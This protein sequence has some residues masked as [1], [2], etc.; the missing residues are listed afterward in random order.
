MLVLVLVLAL[1]QVLV[2][3]LVLELVLVVVY[4]SISGLVVEV[5]RQQGIGRSGLPQRVEKRPHGPVA[6][7]ARASRPETRASGLTREQSANLL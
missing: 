1:A 5:L 6:R 2:L 4:T 7:A 3:V